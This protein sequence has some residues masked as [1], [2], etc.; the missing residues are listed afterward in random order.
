MCLRL[1]RPHS[2]KVDDSAQADRQAME[3]R[4]LDAVYPNPLFQCHCGE[5]SP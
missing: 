1:P 4:S 3:N 5:D 2:A